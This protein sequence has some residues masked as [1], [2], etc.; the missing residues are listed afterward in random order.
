MRIPQTP[1]MNRLVG[2]GSHSLVQYINNQVREPD[3]ITL[4]PYIFS[5]DNTFL[6]YNR[7]RHRSSDSLT[8][9]PFK[10]GLPV[11]SRFG[12]D[13]AWDDVINSF[14]SSLTTNFIQ[15]FA[16]L[17]RY[18]QSVRQYLHSLG[19]S[20]LEINW[21]ETFLE[22][23]GHFDLD[24]TEIVFE[25]WL[26][27]SDVSYTWTTIE[28]GM[29]RLIN[30]MEAILKKPIHYSERVTAINQNAPNSSSI[31]LTSSSGNTFTYDHIINT[32]PLGA[33]QA[34]DMSTLNLDH[35]TESAI[36]MI[37]YDSSMKLGIRFKSRWW[38][39]F[40]NP[41]FGGQSTSDLPIRTCVYP[42]HGIHVPDAAAVLIASYTWGQDASRLSAYLSS[43]P[44]SSSSSS[45]GGDGGTFENIPNT[46]PRSASENLLLNLT[47]TSL[48][49]LHNVSLSFLR[50]QYLD[51]FAHSWYDNPF[52]I[53]AF[54]EFGPGQ[55][56]ELMPL[57]MQPVGKGGR[58]H[59]GGDA[60]S[61]GHAW[62]VGGLNAGFRCVRE[63]LEGEGRKG[64]VR[65]LEEMW[66][67]LVSRPFRI[68]HLWRGV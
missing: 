61:A 55:F 62:I 30:G 32:V 34:M 49:T 24:L 12:P 26:F 28:G 1:F 11:F 52:S 47:L 46:S 59:L 33:M 19:F 64:D 13:V 45:S 6:Y 31:T 25:D 48:A 35:A 50:S 67:P 18:G 15:G 3:K 44:S 21:L 53:G 37:N 2:N 66:G 10:T 68:L 17:S 36:R 58:L 56:A 42:S 51:H 40:P 14:I 7:I 5:N 60:L 27:G 57:L 65:R 29:S 4:I 39:D 43:N 23:T 20:F 41:I 22:A 9:D 54:P 16:Q 38:Q 8:G 63:I